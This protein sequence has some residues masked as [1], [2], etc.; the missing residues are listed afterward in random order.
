MPGWGLNPHMLLTIQG[1]GVLGIFFN[2]ACERPREMGPIH[3]ILF[4]KGRIELSW[5]LNVIDEANK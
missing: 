3:S 5:Y 2:E 1:V 4:A